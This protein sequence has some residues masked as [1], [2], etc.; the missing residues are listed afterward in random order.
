MSLRVMTETWEL[1]GTV[2]TWL[3]AT[4]RRGVVGHWNGGPGKRK[5]T[6]ASWERSLGSHGWKIT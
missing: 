2:G 6:L 4:G 1:Q 3:H 5:Q